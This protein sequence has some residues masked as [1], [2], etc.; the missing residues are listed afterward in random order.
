V[1]RGQQGDRDRD[2]QSKVFEPIRWSTVSDGESPDQMGRR[3]HQGAEI[4]SAGR[5]NVSTAAGVI[6][7]INSWLKIVLSCD[8]HG[9]RRPS[10]DLERRK[11]AP[12]GESITADSHTCI[13]MGSY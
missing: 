7:R 1:A 10:I 5:V 9:K 12:I 3:F 13:A 6:H 2:I 11:M 4:S 8:G